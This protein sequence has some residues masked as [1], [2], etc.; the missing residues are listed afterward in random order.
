MVKIM[1]AVPFALKS[2][3][4]FLLILFCFS[5]ALHAA[6][7]KEAL[8]IANGKYSHFAGLANPG[9]DSAK[10][11]AALEQLGFRVRVVRDGNREQMLDAISEFERGLR[12]T[13]AIAFFHYGGHGVQVDGKNYL[14]PADADIPDERRVATRAVA[15]DEVMTAMDAAEA[16]ASIIVIDACRDNPLPAGSGRNLAR[17]LSVVGMKP[18]NSIV[19]YAAEAGSKALD[20]LF[21][22]IL[23]VALQQKGRTIDQVMKSVRSEV[24]AKS[25]GLQTPGEYNQLFEELFLGESAG[26]DLAPEKIFTAKPAP[27]PTHTP[28][29]ESTVAS[30]PPEVTLTKETMVSLNVG[31]VSG[32]AKISPGKTFKVV[33]VDGATVLVTMGA[34]TVRIPKENSNFAEALDAAIALAEKGQTSTANDDTHSTATALLSASTTDIGRQVEIVLTIHGARSAEVPQS[35][36]VPG[37][38]IEYS[39]SS[40]KFE[41]NNYKIASTLTYRYSVLPLKS[42]IFEIPPFEVVVGKKILKTKILQLRVIGKTHDPLADVKERAQ[43]G[44]AKAQHYLGI[45]YENGEGPAKDMG[46]AMKWYRKAAEQGLAEAQINLGVCYGSGEGVAK[47]MGEAV[48]WFRKAADQGHAYAQNILGLHYA[49]GEGVAK[50]AL[51][52]VEWFRK[53]ADQGHAEAQHNLGVCYDRGEGVPKHEAEAVKWYRKAADQGHAEAQHNLGCCYAE[54]KGVAKDVLE[55]VKWYRKAADQGLAE[56]QINLGVCYANGNGVGKDMVEAYAFF[57]LASITGYKNIENMD[58]AAK[59]MTSD[60]IAAAQKRTKELQKE[61]RGN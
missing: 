26:D 57:N 56:A 29:T 21:T 34:S 61:L 47:D 33:G 5:A 24:Y 32:S 13:G 17:G 44:D 31:G 49:E 54:G 38:R 11:G 6:Q 40:K 48:E 53:A 27:T 4:A 15:L 7:P 14:L 36:N 37:L 52:A 1:K 41:M 18:K 2:H 45:C 19:I 8:L 46:E 51:K 35:L 60:Q 12:N 16:R 28:Y 20:G 42:G 10:L 30:Y 43:Q 22:P 59:K 55:A 39:D 23:A 9:P 3:N 50:D 58:L 25:S